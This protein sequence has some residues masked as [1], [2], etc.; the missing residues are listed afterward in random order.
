MP[1]GYFTKG[2]GVTHLTQLKM[3]PPLTTL[4]TVVKN[5]CLEKNVSIIQVPAKN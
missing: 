5:N 2:I 1:A 4:T 3:P